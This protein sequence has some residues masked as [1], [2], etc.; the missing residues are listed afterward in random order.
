LA[1]VRRLKAV[2]EASSIWVEPA[3]RR[4]AAKRMP[5]A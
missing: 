3:A 1:I 4:Q 2:S 5:S